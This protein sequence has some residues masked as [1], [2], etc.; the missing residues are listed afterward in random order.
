LQFIGKARDRKGILL[1]VKSEKTNWDVGLIF[2][3]DS[4]GGA[5]PRSV[6]RRGWEPWMN[7]FE[8]Y[9]KEVSE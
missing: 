1:I 3:R 2:K 4:A 6:L 9:Q 8:I 5:A 7:K